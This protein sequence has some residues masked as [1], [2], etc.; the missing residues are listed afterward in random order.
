MEQSVK[1]K[2][3]YGKPDVVWMQLG[4]VNELAAEAAKKTGL[5]VVM[6]KCMMVEHK[7]F[8]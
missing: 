8:F 2:A 4:I 6:D 7:R 5:V 3:A 1:L